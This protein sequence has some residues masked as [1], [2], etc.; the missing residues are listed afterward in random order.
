MADDFKY[1]LCQ[2]AVKGH[3]IQKFVTMKIWTLLMFVIVLMSCG[4]NSNNYDV[5]IFADSSDKTTFFP[6][7]NEIEEF[8]N[9]LKKYL[10]DKTQQ[11]ATI[12]YFVL[13][14]KIP[15]Q[16]ALKYYKRRV[17]GKIMPNKNKLVI[18]E[19]VFTRCAGGEEW[20]KKDYTNFDNKA[21]WWFAEYNL[22]D[23]SM[24]NFVYK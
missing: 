12:Y 22:T 3:K 19:F 23:K 8:N 21:C 18:V 5:Q 6:T 24:M 20:R 16:Q 7:E 17:F 2:L 4:R 15:L 14:E 1:R 9:G 10:D 11:N 13:N